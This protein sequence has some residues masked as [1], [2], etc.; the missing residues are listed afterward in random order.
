MQHV[1]IFDN[2]G[3]GTVTVVATRGC[4][5]FTWLDAALTAPPTQTC[6]TNEPIALFAAWS[7]DSADGPGFVAVASTSGGGMAV[8]LSG[9]GRISAEQLDATVFAAAPRGYMQALGTVVKKREGPAWMAKMARGSGGYSW[10]ESTVSRL[11]ALQPRPA[12]PHAPALDAQLVQTVRAAL[13][14]PCGADN[15]GIDVSWTYRLPP[16][17]P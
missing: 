4:D 3:S 10:L 5:V 2:K 16:V 7:L 17:L 15:L 13:C 11:T 12:A 14:V 6:A 9:Q 1:H 8:V